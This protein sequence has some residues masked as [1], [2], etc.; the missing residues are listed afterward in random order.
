MYKATKL[1]AF[2]LDPVLPVGA[3]QLRQSYFFFSTTLLS[4]VYYRRIKTDPTLLSFNL[5]D[6]R[7]YQGLAKAVAISPA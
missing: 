1:Y 4:R 7:L 3:R 2:L 6:Y 5:A